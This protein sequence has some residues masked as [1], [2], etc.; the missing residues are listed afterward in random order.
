MDPHRL[1]E[2]RS[3]AM[4]AAIAARLVAEPE[5]V[6]RA[7]QRVAGWLADGSV[8]RPYAE[9]WRQLLALP[10][11]ELARTLVD[12]GERARALRQAS[13]FAGALPPA[14]R[15]AIRRAVRARLEAP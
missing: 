9:A 15:W 8:A 14:E 13:P 1:G 11:A 7:R 2:E 6:S 5:L 4:H 10:P 3:I 12:P